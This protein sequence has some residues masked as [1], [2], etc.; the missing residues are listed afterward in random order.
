MSE[1][2]TIVSG[3]GHAEIPPD[4]WSHYL[5]SEFHEYLPLAREDNEM[6]ARQTE[7]FFPITPEFLEVFD[8]EGRYAAG[9][10]LGVWDLDRRLAEMDR[11]GVAAELINQGDAR[12]IGLFMPLYREYPEAVLAAGR[13]AYHRWA[14]DALGGATDRLL[15]V[16]DAAAAVSMDEMLSELR[17]LGDH[18]FA[19]TE[20]PFKVHRPEM[21]PLYDSYYDPFWSACEDQGFPLVVHAGYGLE[22]AEFMTKMKA[23]EEQMRAAG[24][25]NILEEVH[26]SSENFL[27]LDLRPRR[28]LW[29][30]M[31]GGVFD[32]HPRL[33]V[34]LV[35]IRGDWLPATL[36]NLDEVFKRSAATLPAKRPPSEYWKSNCLVGLSFVHKAEVGIRQQIGIDTITFGRDYPHHEGT[37]P[38]TADWL[39]DAFRGVPDDELRLILGENSMRF[40]GLDRTRLAQIADR[41]GPTIDQIT[42]RTPSLDPRLVEHFDHRGGYLK[43]V[44]QVDIDAMDVLLR[45]DVSGASQRGR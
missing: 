22:Q 35:E 5:D 33:K 31:L 36:R 45:Q 7:Q 20:M 43:P 11:E 37:W 18:G 29:Q 9:G 26:G 23:I 38:N 12:A 15:L 19:A 17:W 4:V 24:R 8:T 13:R 6:W 34:A 41:I 25:T 21:P 2:L 30:L 10:Y 3:D 1:R 16:G 42:G 44:E 28:A 40:F 27:A 39:T 32:R 14:A